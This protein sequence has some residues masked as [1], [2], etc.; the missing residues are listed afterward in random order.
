M[1]ALWC[2]ATTLALMASIGL[3]PAM[4]QG[5]K[6]S[7]GKTWP[8]ISQPV[9][10]DA[11]PAHSANPSFQGASPQG[12]SQKGFVVL[13]FDPEAAMIKPHYE[14]QYYYAGRHAHWEGH[15]I[16][17]TAPIQSAKAPAIPALRN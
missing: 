8:G 6:P 14:W 15:W 10:H 17:V 3:A 13:P 2:C 5:P 1:K 12:T 4:A 7:G 16:L 9:E 11:V